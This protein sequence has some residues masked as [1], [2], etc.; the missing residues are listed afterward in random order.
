M[1][2]SQITDRYDT[3]LYD[4]HIDF[5][6]LKHTTVL[7]ILSYDYVKNLA[8]QI[9]LIFYVLMELVLTFTTY[10]FICNPITNNL[11]FVVGTIQ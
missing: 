7:G 1:Q 8:I 5:L 3:L 6:G 2:R 4:L 10:P 9:F 11:G